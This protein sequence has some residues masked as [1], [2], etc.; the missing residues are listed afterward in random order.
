MRVAYRDEPAIGITVNL[1]RAWKRGEIDPVTGAS[2][3]KDYTK[4]HVWHIFSSSP[5]PTGCSWCAANIPRARRSSWSSV[6]PAESSTCPR[7]RC[8]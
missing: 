6:P 8:C 5:S 3:L 4:N 1:I 2:G 7:E